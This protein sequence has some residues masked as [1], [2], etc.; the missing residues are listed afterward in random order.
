MEVKPKI[1]FGYIMHKRLFPKINSFNY[2][3]YYLQLPLSQINSSL[4]NKF[5]KINHW[6]LLSFYNRDHGYR[7]NENLENWARNTL[8]KH[9]I[10]RADGEII[11][12]TMP[13]VLGYVFNPISFWY[14]YSQT[15]TL[16]AIICEVNNTFG[17]SH[18]YV[19]A[20]NDQSEITSKDTLEGIK[21]FHVSPFLEREGVYKFRFAPKNDSMGVWIDLYD[22][23]GQKKLITT[24]TGKTKEWNQDHLFHA[25]WRYPLVTF[26][27]IFLIHWQAIKLFIKKI[28]FV[29]KPIQLKNK[30]TRTTK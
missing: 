8:K 14:C 18:S 2:R 26:K 6:G 11:L 4:E 7:N 21:S 22:A 5:F 9:H 29:P 23:Q 30:T 1:I 3:I 20:H 28:K 10:T 24:L 25:F 12:V 27:A 19:C 16:R 17:E 13:R 15:G